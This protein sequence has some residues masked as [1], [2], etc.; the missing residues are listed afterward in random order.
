MRAIE[1][2]GAGRLAPAAAMEAISAISH[3][4]PA[5]IWLFTLAAAAGAVA[6]ASTLR[7][8]TSPRGGAHLRERGGRCH[9]APPLGAVQRKRF[10]ATILRGVARWRYRRAGGSV[11]V[12]LVTAPC[13][14]LPRH[15]PGAGTACAQWRVGPHQGPR[16]SWRRPPDLCGARDCRDL[17]GTAAWTRPSRGLLTGRPGWQGRAPVARHHCRRR[18]R[19]LLQRLLLYAAAYAGLAGGGRH[20]GP[21]AQVGGAYRAWLQRQ[22]PAPWS[23]VSSSG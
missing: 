8:P 22:Q 5:P 19:R 7:C 18:R 4:P 15:G 6:L 21:C 13:R 17:D 2:L 10:P 14:G 3:A 11:P 12:E 9:A 16:P 20:A 23:L 1:E